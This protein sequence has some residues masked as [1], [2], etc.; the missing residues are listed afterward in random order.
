MQINIQR[1]IIGGMSK[2]QIEVKKNQ[3]ENN[4][5]LLRRFSRRMFESG[6][7]QKVKS[8]RYNE[9]PKSKLSQKVTTIRRIV[10]RKEIERLKKLGK[11]AEKV[12]RGPRR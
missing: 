6:S 1:G 9:R 3:N 8:K 2:T 12:E 10:K 11:I 5:S 7:I 4:T